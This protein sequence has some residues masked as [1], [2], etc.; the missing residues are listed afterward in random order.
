[1]YVSNWNKHSLSTYSLTLN[2][3][4]VF[5]R[6]RWILQNIHN[7]KWLNANCLSVLYNVWVIVSYLPFICFICC[8]NKSG[9]IYTKTNTYFC[10]SKLSTITEFGRCKP[11]CRH[12]LQLR[13]RLPVYHL[14]ALSSYNYRSLL[15]LL[16]TQHTL[17]CLLTGNIWLLGT[18][19][20]KCL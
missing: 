16:I 14:I 9:F 11:R 8:L 10:R 5:L 7:Q 6:L 2:I 20:F 17:C 19:P 3:G 18:I 13:C 4:Y 15:D 1:M 12:L